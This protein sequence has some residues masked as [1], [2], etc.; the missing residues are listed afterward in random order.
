VWCVELE[1]LKLT[2]SCAGIAAVPG[3]ACLTSPPPENCQ[4]SKPHEGRCAELVVCTKHSCHS[5][6]VER[7]ERHLLRCVQTLSSNTEWFLLTDPFQRTETDPVSKICTLPNT[8]REAKSTNPN[9][10]TQ[11]LKQPNLNLWKFLEINY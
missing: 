3:I 1:P 8:R 10:N 5:T 6:R 2:V 11:K 4:A 9:C 7:Q